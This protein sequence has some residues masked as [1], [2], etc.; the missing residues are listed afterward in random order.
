M[1]QTV[2]KR[3]EQDLDWSRQAFDF[4]LRL[5]FQ[6]I[7]HHLSQQNFP[8]TKCNWVSELFHATI[9]LYSV[10]PFK[11]KNRDKI[12]LDATNPNLKKGSDRF[13]SDSL[14]YELLCG[15]I[16]WKV[17]YSSNKILSMKFYSSSLELS[18]LQTHIKVYRLGCRSKIYQNLFSD[19][20]F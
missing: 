15:F 8:H 10:K 2:W 6:H 3:W 12:D 7:Q 1:S 14:T 9:C 18:T 16:G 11:S 4:L 20:D 5:H 17:P 13:S 19:W